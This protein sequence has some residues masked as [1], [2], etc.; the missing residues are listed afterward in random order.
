MQGEFKNARKASGLV[1]PR[2]RRWVD[3]YGLDPTPSRAYRA[4][5][6]ELE[7]EDWDSAYRLLIEYQCLGDIE[8]DFDSY[9]DEE[10][11]QIAHDEAK[12]HFEEHGYVEC[13]VYNSLSSVTVYCI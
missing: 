4:N 1:T 11:C 2:P 9:E 5:C 12:A 6:H 13:N 10:F 8:G 3:R 7:A